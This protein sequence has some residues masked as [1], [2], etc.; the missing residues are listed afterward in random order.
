MIEAID[1]VKNWVQLELDSLN[2]E[3]AAYEKAKKEFDDESQTLKDLKSNHADM[4]RIKNKHVDDKNNVEINLS[5]LG[6]EIKDLLKD[7]QDKCEEIAEQKKYIAKEIEDFKEMEHPLWKTSLTKTIDKLFPKNDKDNL[8]MEE[9]EFLRGYERAKSINSSLVK[10]L[11]QQ[12]KEYIDGLCVANK[13]SLSDENIREK[14]GPTST[15][16]DKNLE[17]LNHIANIINQCKIMVRELEVIKSN[18]NGLNVNN[19]IR[20]KYK[21]LIKDKNKLEQHIANDDETLKGLQIDIKSQEGI[22]DNKRN[23]LS[24]VQ[25]SEGSDVEKAKLKTLN[26]LYSIIK[27]SQ[28]MSVEPL[29]K[30][31]LEEANRIFDLVKSAPKLKLVL[32]DDYRPGIVDGDEFYPVGSDGQTLTALYSVSLALTLVA[33]GDL[34]LFLDNPF[35]EIDEPT[36]KKI[37]KTWHE[38]KDRQTFVLSHPTSYKEDPFHVENMKKNFTN[39]YH[40]GFDEKYKDDN[41]YSEL[42]TYD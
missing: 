35:H 1:K 37:I 8:K 6:P 33:T 21:K 14:I 28:E 9:K 18:Q 11:S 10:N 17:K 26:N 38:L 19:N 30:K 5:Q 41:N 15:E 22:V 39:S 31:F 25:L 16:Y 29:Q 13:E 42:V 7:E 34:P 2:K 27:R 20:T 32:D 40:Y 36:K 3:D 24:Q 4:I 23:K 12:A